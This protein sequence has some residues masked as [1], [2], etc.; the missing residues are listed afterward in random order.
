MNNHFIVIK[1]L[2]KSHGWIDYT[3]VPVFYVDSSFSTF[4]NHLS[5]NI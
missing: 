5:L 3:V 1:L 2:N 4:R